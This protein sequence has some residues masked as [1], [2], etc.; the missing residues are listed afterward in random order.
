MADDANDT[1]NDI[2][3]PDNRC[4]HRNAYRDERRWVSQWIAACWVVWVN[5]CGSCMDCHYDVL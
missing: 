4:K 1:N 3:E 2:V 5:R